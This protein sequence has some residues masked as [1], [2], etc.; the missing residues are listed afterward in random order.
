[1]LQKGRSRRPRRPHPPAQGPRRRQYT[2]RKGRDHTN[3]PRHARRPRLPHR[4]A[5]TGTA[6]LITITTP[7]G[8]RTMIRALLH[9]LT[10]RLPCRLIDTGGAPYMERYYVGQGLGAT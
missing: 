2:R 8:K 5:A 4:R 10:A 6:A 1:G 3:D 7:R 9:K